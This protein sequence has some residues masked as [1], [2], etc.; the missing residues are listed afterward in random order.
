VLVIRVSRALRAF[1]AQVRGAPLHQFVTSVPIHFSFLSFVISIH[2]LFEL[3]PSLKT[4]HAIDPDRIYITGQ[5]MGGCSTFLA[6]T[7]RPELLQLRRQ[8]VE[9]AKQS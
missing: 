9:E 2:V 3:I 7:L 5:S 6:I 4:K 8:F 1:A